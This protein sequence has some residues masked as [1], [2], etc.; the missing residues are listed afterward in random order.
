MKRTSEE[1]QREREENKRRSALHTNGWQ[2]VVNVSRRLAARKERKGKASNHTKDKAG[3]NLSPRTH[4]V[5]EDQ[6][7]KTPTCVE[8][9]S[10]F[11][12]QRKIVYKQYSS[13]SATRA[14]LQ[15][16]HGWGSTHGGCCLR[17]EYVQSINFHHKNQRLVIKQVIIKTSNKVYCWWIQ[18]GPSSM[19]A[20]LWTF[21]QRGSEFLAL[22]SVAASSCRCRSAG[23]ERRW[24]IT[25]DRN[26][27]QETGSSVFSVCII[28][29]LKLIPEA[30]ARG[31]YL[32]WQAHAS[33]MCQNM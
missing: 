30:H 10:F 18:W 21:M 7:S 24:Q 16:R 32:K 20:D 13:T 25:G 11:L 28:L 2:I 12:K 8:I 23:D 26:S 22:T 9:Q 29:F 3:G 19:W 17:E 5:G 15:W 31:L 4:L 14:A 1:K 27:S 6:R 33:G